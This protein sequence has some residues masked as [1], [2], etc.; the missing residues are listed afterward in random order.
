MRVAFTPFIFLS[1]ETEK[2]GS[3]SRKLQTLCGVLSEMI[4]SRGMEKEKGVY[5]MVKGEK[6]TWRIQS[7]AQPASG[8]LQS[9]NHRKFCTHYEKHRYPNCIRLS[10]VVAS[11]SGGGGGGPDWKLRI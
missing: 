7:G 1:S 5:G 2:R 6:G 3:E 10:L 8:G 9:P 4:K 11:W